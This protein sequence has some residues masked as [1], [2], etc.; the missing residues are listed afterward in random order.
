MT[1]I[2][3]DLL[4]SNNTYAQHFHYGELT[5]VPKRSLAVVM[6]MD[7]RL[8]AFGFLGI[9]EGDAHI[10]RNAGGIVTD[11]V[12]RALAISQHV[13]GTREVAIVQHHDCRGQLIPEQIDLE[14]LHSLPTDYSVASVGDAY[15]S[16][17]K[18]VARVLDSPLI[19]HKD[20]VRGYVYD[21]QT[22]LLE[23]VEFPQSQDKPSS[24]A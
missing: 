16:V 19:T 9:S 8:R 1:P 10:I 12:I 14:I 15:A 17:R 18:S 6:C 21:V 13:F 5:P 3:D 7:A 24:G 20:A 2:T 22:G 4:T 11:D 23:L